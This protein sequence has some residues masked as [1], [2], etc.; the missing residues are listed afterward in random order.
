MELTNREAGMKTVNL[1]TTFLRRSVIPLIEEEAAAT[2]VVLTAPT[3][4]T[5]EIMVATSST[6]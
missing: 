4:I 1:P 6:P 5:S 2:E 3:P